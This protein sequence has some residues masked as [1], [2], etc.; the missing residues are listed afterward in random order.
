[1]FLDED[2]AFNLK[3]LS[4]RSEPKSNLLQ[5]PDLFT[6]LEGTLS[7]SSPPEASYPSL[8]DLEKGIPFCNTV[9]PVSLL[10]SSAPEEE[11]LKGCKSGE[12]KLLSGEEEAIGRVV[13]KALL[14]SS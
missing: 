12:S 13:L 1:M 6:I 14:A 2:D 7:L 10:P 3:A 11:T 9:K 5:L 8:V 4:S